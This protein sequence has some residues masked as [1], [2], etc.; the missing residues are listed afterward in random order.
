[1]NH[2]RLPPHYHNL[3]Q[4]TSDTGVMMET[5]VPTKVLKIYIFLAQ[6][7]IWIRVLKVVIDLGY[8]G[9]VKNIHF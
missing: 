5:I 8:L 9:G 7:Y 2:C 1:M 6:I 4:E 3:Q